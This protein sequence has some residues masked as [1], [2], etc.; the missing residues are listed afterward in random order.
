MSVSSPLRSVRLSRL[1]KDIGSVGF[2]NTVKSRLDS[3]PR[4]R[5]SKYQESDEERCAVN[6]D[7]TALT[8]Y[9]TNMDRLIGFPQRGSSA[10]LR[11]WWGRS[12]PDR[13]EA[14]Q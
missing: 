12:R 14:F 13:P 6:M 10:L 4:D 1:W 7:W 11:A 8:W 3:F 2:R 5:W 9:D